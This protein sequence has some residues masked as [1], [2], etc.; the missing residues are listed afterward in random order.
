MKRR[1]HYKILPVLSLVVALLIL[2]RFSVS[3]Q[4][5]NYDNLNATQ[6]AASWLH[7]N[8]D[9]GERG[10][11]FPYIRRLT[12]EIEPLFIKAYRQGPSPEETGEIEKNAAAR[13]DLIQKALKTGRTFGL[14]KEE[15]DIARNQNQNDFIQSQKNGFISGY[16]SR[17]IIGMAV[18]KGPEARKLIEAET[19]N[20]K[21]ELNAAAKEAMKMLNQTN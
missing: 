7:K 14:S 1:S 2:C 20:E 5:T 12:A 17:A 9:E 3:A 10:I 19:K 21:S 18:T 15:L 16:K 8:C 4:Q 13:F 6:L 11:I